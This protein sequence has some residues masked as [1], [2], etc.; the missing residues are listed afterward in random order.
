[1]TSGAAPSGSSPSTTI[2][3]ELWRSLPKVYRARDD[4]EFAALIDVFGALL[5]RV[6]ATLDQRLADSFPADPA[7]GEDPGSGQAWLLP[8]F[9][10]LVDAHLRS[11]H[12]AGRRLEVAQ[13]I[14][15]R[16]RKGTLG[17][18]QDIAEA[19]VG[20]SEAGDAGR[21]VSV[22]EGFTR[23]ATSARIGVPILPPAA[24]G[25]PDPPGPALASPAEAARLPGLP[26]A[27]VDVRQIS[28]AVQ[29]PPDDPQAQRLSF[30]QASP[31]TWRQLNPRGAP[32]F[33]GSFE[34][35]SRRT[36]DI[37]PSR[38]GEGQAEPRRVLLFTAPALGFFDPRLPLANAPVQSSVTLD[39]GGS[40]HGQRV[41]TLTVNGGTVVLA[42]CWV[43]TLALKND[44]RAEITG[45]AV[46]AVQ[47]T[48]ADPGQPPS[49]VVSASDSLC[50]TID[51]GGLVRLVYCTVLDMA[52]ASQLQASDTIFAG[53]VAL[54]AA[55][56]GCVRYSRIAARLPVAI[57]RH[58]NTSAEPVFLELA[59]CATGDPTPQQPAWGDP[60]SGV[61]DVA[62]PTSIRFGAEDGGEMG[63]YHAY[64]LGL[65]DQAVVD[66]ATDHMPLAVAPVL[67]SD[68]RL[69]HVP[70]AIETS[71]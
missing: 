24:F 45:S 25:E 26:A 48:A 68:Q 63:A 1:M 51:A 21:E 49:P 23:V 8:Y 70:P 58:A 38:G 46:R 29:C 64:A 62:T 41:G 32:C 12:A 69:L 15:W 16:K 66:K 22:Q 34:D 39:A 35:R 31:I 67:I 50:E 60:G 3:G 20:P 56:R 54:P 11:P 17:L 10:Q 37:R 9:A 52:R 57:E 61:L 42:G 27:F 19:I 6:R 59:A 4:G 65:E 30:A 28:R 53:E 18:V 13:A 36:V 2:G 71:G 5:D 14:D 55:A 44:A 33:P 43:D 47:S 7:A 40:L